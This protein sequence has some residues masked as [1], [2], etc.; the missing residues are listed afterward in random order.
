MMEVISGKSR[1]DATTHDEKVESYSKFGEV[2]KLRIG[3]SPDLKKLCKDK[4]IQKL[5]EESAKKLAEETNSKIVELELKNINLAIQTYY[6][7]V[8]VEFFSATRKLDGRKYGKKIEDSCGEEALRRILGGQEISKAEHK[9]TYY[10]TA[11]KTKSL[12]TK[13]LKK[14]FEKV[15]VI[16]S[17][18]TPVLPHKLG[19]KMNDPRVMYAYDAFTIPANLA[20][21]CAASIPA[22][23]VKGI[24]VGMHVMTESFKEKLLF[25][26]LNKW[27]KI[28]QR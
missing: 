18:V 23:K 28:T 24:P 12:I 20:G 11:L 16:I 27:Q 4:E 9:G 10:R 5:I 7:I 8:Y 6:P 17:P 14:A 19:E 1:N 21:F 26:I 2:K 13:E 3:L 25:D 22:G 15:D